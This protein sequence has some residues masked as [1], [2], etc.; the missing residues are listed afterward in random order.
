M[1][2]FSGTTPNKISG[3]KVDGATFDSLAAPGGAS[4]FGFN[5]GAA[6]GQTIDNTELDNITITNTRFG[7]LFDSMNG[8]A[9][10]GWNGTGLDTQQDD[11]VGLEVQNG[12]NLTLKN[13]SI[14]NYRAGIGLQNNGTG[15]VIDGSTKGVI[16][17]IGTNAT[18]SSTGLS[19]N[20]T[21]VS[22]NDLTISGVGKA[23]ADVN[24]DIAILI[25]GPDT[26]KLTRVHIDGK[27]TGGTSVT[28]T[29]I[30]LGGTTPAQSITI[31]SGSDNNTAIN[32]PTIC[33]N[34][35]SGGAT[36]TGA[37]N[38]TTPAATTCP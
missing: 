31:L 28:E 29:G 12:S 14:S 24:P 27:N 15:N 11:N 10:N 6:P 34:N 25:G 30:L 17:D 23:A 20:S 37:I 7:A 16:K 9:I 32:V 21:T 38:F 4:G 19:I 3:L 8:L 22:V 33:N 36:V 13:F 26:V 5:T 1:L 18:V 2:M 35:T